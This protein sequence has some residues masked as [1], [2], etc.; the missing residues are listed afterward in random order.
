MLTD[1]IPCNS[2]DGD[3]TVDDNCF[4]KQ[5]F[6]TNSGSI[7]TELTYKA[8][9]STKYCFEY[10]Q[11]V[12]HYYCDRWSFSGEWIWVDMFIGSNGL[13]SGCAMSKYSGQ[14]TAYPDYKIQSS[15]PLIGNDVWYR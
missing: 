7:W 10:K 4:N 2:T 9:Y 12:N 13:Y 14:S 8:T 11:W 1:A 6:I 3:N 5:Y 15:C